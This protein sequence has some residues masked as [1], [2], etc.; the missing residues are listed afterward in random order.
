M[1]LTVTAVWMWQK[2]SPA[3][4]GH[5]VAQLPSAGLGPSHP[6][7]FP[8]VELP[9]PVWGWLVSSCRS[10]EPWPRGGL[11]PSLA[12]TG[13]EFAPLWCPSSPPVQAALAVG[14]GVC[15]W[16]TLPPRPIFIAGVRAVGAPVWGACWTHSA[17]THDHCDAVPP[18]GNPSLNW[19]WEKLAV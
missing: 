5:L 4:L 16:P 14:D 10:A 17:V 7:S 3:K 13:L 2:C 9:V 18:S 12:G 15:M 1:A 11:A 6:F 8:F 19:V